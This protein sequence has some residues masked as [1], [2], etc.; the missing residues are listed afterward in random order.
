[1]SDTKNSLS[2]LATLTIVGLFA[3]SAMAGDAATVSE[4]QAE[5][6]AIE[7]SEATEAAVEAAPELSDAELQS[8][9]PAAG[10]AE[11]AAEA[12]AE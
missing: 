6:T 7:A 1:M 10:G 3:A 4:E 12:S 11:D 9:Q 2:A 5:S 8:L